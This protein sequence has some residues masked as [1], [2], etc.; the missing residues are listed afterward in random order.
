VQRLTVEVVATTP[1]DPGSYTQGLVHHDGVVYES[2]GNYGQSDVRRVDRATGAVALQ[3]D[4]D[5]DEFGEG[6][7]LVDDALW[8]LTWKE[9]GVNV[10]DAA[11]LQLRRTVGYE[12]EG[13]GLCHDGDRLVMSDGSSQL[14][15]RDADT[16]AVLGTVPVTLEGEPVERLNE[17]EC[18]DGTVLANVYPS[19]LIVWIDP[20]SGRVTATVDAAPLRAMA[21]P[22]DGDEVLNGIA[23]IQGID[24][25]LLTGKHWPTMFEVRFVPVTS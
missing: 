2:A 14:T 17:L 5:P 9:G 16:F 20:A 10:V 1:H 15:F 6:L 18:V 25:F 21:G 12:G 13:W 22:L 3:R 7:A 4:N 11:T 24:H 8:Q 23:H 19:D